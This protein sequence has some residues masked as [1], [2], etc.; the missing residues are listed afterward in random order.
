[1]IPLEG[2]AWGWMLETPIVNV[3][4]QVDKLVRAPG[5][6]DVDAM[7]VEWTDSVR[8][9]RLDPVAF[10]AGLRERQAK[11]AAM[12]ER[13]EKAVFSAVP[14]A[15]GWYPCSVVPPD[16]EQVESRETRGWR[17]RE[18]SEWNDV[19]PMDDDGR[20]L[21]TWYPSGSPERPDGVWVMCGA[22]SAADAIE[23]GG[24]WRHEPDEDH[25]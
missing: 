2:R 6:K 1:M 24:R 10:R 7:L 4:T 17:F 25:P 12:I 19:P 21:W 14:D 23:H 8:A 20:W 13:A 22:D 16:G 5:P 18:G 11:I 9:G 15:A 3:H